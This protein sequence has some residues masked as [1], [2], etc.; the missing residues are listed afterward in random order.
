M[1][2]ESGFTLVEAVVALGIATIMFTALAYSAVAA[3][4]STQIAR[5]NQQAIDLAN[6]QLESLRQQPWGTLESYVREDGTAAISDSDVRENNIA[7]SI[8]TYVTTPP[9]STGEF[10]LRVVVSWNDYGQSRERVAE[11]SVSNKTSGLPLPDFE[12]VATTPDDIT[13]SPD[14]AAV[15][16]FQLVNRGAWDNWTIAA[17]PSGLTLYQDR[18]SSTDATPDG[19]FD[20]E[21][22]QPITE[23]GLIDPYDSLSFWAVANSTSELGI[24]TWQGSASSL[25]Q[26]SATSGVQSWTMRLEV[27]DAT[28]PPVAGPICPDTTNQG[29]PSPV[30]G[31]SVV[32]Y[33]LH[34]S[35]K[36]PWPPA[37]AT[38]P[39][40]G[41]DATN[42]LDLT[43][44]DGALPSSWTLPPYSMNI[45]PTTP[46]RVIEP[47]ES[48]TT[49]AQNAQFQMLRDRLWYTGTA[50][51]W[52]FIRNLDPGTPAN[53]TVELTK[54]TVSGSTASYATL[55]NP[56]DAEVNSC[57]SGAGYRELVLEFPLSS[58]VKLNK[59]QYLGFR[60]L[61]PGPNDVSLAYDHDGF[62]SRITVVEK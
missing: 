48:T 52:L 50:K 8:D 18:T 6:D 44:N 54:V 32:T 3:V 23:T 28:Q 38:D 29:N 10:Q 57:D 37:G 16:G 1:R 51:V 7:Y 45:A 12:V 61:N 35:G 58:V 53:V 34:N 4:R 25:T 5:A 14:S 9:N 27:A 31:Y 20:S 39:V 30:N 59:N 60:V 19:Q 43:T 47:G 55:G 15:W 49:P 33:F 41:T 17:T 22:D 36:V 13:V 56:I 62:P 21:V 26:P 40:T 2:R 24:R 46:G 42:P 11:T